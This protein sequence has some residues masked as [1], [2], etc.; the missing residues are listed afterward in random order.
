M[1]VFAW[2][3]GNGIILQFWWFVRIVFELRL[4]GHSFYKVCGRVSSRGLVL[5]G[6]YL[7]QDGRRSRIGMGKDLNKLTSSRDGLSDCVTFI[8][9]RVWRTICSASMF[10]RRRANCRYGLGSFRSC[11]ICYSTQGLGYAVVESLLLFLLGYVSV[12]GHWNSCPEYST[13]SYL[14]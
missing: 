11:D 13:F 8:T 1:G 3:M 7:Q 10:S 5:G 9:E 2:T 6:N 12:I 14:L 4:H